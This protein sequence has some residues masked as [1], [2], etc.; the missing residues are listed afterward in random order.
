MAL[1]I[2]TGAPCSGKST[3]VR[4]HLGPRDLVFDHDAVARAITGK[5][6]HT[7]TDKSYAIKTIAAMRNAALEAWRQ[8]CTGAENFYVIASSAYYIT[9]F[10][11]AQEMEY[12]VI[13]LDTSQAECLARLQKDDSRPEKTLWA[14]IIQR[15]FDRR[16]QQMSKQA[17]RSADGSTLTLYV[18]E[19]IRPDSMVYNWNSGKYD[20]V[21]SVTSQRY[22]TEQ[23]EGLTAD[24][25]VVL[26]INSMGGSVKEAL[27][28]VNA[29]RRCPARVTAYVD[30]FAA[31]AASVIT[32]GADEILMPRNTCMMLHNARWV[33]EGN[34][35]ELRKSADD[36]EVINTTIIS[37]YAS[38]AGNK[39]SAAMLRK[40][41][42]E[43]TWLTAEDCVKYG[44]AD[45]FAEYD[46][47]LDRAA[48]ALRSSPAAA[49]NA[50]HL[51][52]TL[53]A[54]LRTAPAP[55][56]ESPAPDPEPRNPQ[57]GAPVKKSAL[58]KLAEAIDK[59]EVK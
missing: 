34:P 49:Q 15:W 53:A 31:S 38:R 18:M 24:N 36:L 33:T 10:I 23:L 6:L 52:D 20:R 25:R 28:I 1:Y 4:E 37:S 26:Y 3:Y 8:G 39:L 29:L 56:P 32:Q 40:I 45:G 41:L 16:E 21:E 57:A 19:D 11:A 9:A 51:P 50:G 43:E 12:T 14:E 17:E 58:E 42:D 48:E 2:V 54:R 22:I 27:G 7:L 44:L 55:Q 35:K 46:A 30:G 59:M 47:D 5:P 13:E